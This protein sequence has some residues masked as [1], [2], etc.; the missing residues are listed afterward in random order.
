MGKSKKRRHEQEDILREL[1]KRVKRMEDRIEE[2]LSSG[3]PE[4]DRSGTARTGAS[5][6]NGRQRRQS[7]L[8]STDS[9]SQRSTPSSK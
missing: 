7:K 1:L 8:D 4:A 9:D 3:Y 2:K 6:E 5:K